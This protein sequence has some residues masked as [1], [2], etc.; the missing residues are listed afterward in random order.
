MILSG[1]KEGRYKGITFWQRRDSTV[2]GHV[3]GTGGK[4]DISGTFYFPGA[5]LDIKGNG[6]VANIGSQYISDQLNLGGN[7]GIHIDWDPAKVAPKRS[8]FLVE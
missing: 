1:P 3:E 6:G 7:G 5:L 8:I 4:T 2:T